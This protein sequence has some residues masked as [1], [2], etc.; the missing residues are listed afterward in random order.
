MCSESSVVINAE[1]EDWEYK[2]SGS[3]LRRASAMWLM[4]AVWMV[5]FVIPTYQ[6]A[7]TVRG[8]GTH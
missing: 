3:I 1:G 7:R 5:Q 2:A 4:Y 8:G 6:C